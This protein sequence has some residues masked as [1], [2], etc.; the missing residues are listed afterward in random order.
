MAIGS[1]TVISKEMFVARIQDR[2]VDDGR[3]VERRESVS[4]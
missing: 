3:N 2:L 1:A 4:E